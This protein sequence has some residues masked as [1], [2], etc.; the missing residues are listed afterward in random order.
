[1]RSPKR[2]VWLLLLAVPS[3]VP[4]AAS[5]EP[6]G[7][8]SPQGNPFSQTSFVPDISFILDAGAVVRNL[9]DAGLGELVVPGF[10]EA[11]PDGEEESGPA[12]GFNLNYAEMGIHSTVDPYFDVTAVFHLHAEGFEIEE[13]YFTTRLLPFGLR[14]TGG[15]FLSAVTRVNEQHAHAWDFVDAPLI[16]RVLFGGEGLNETGVRVDWV[17]P[18]SSYW[19]VGAEWLS[20]ANETSFG[21][22]GFRDASG[23]VTVRD[24]R[25][26]GLA[27]VLLR[28][29][30]DAGP[31]AL[32]AGLSGAAGRTLRDG[33]LE[34]GVTG[35]EAFEAD[36]RLACAGLTGRWSPTP[37]RSMTAQLEFMR[38][39]STGTRY[40]NA[41]SGEAPASPVRRRQSGLYGQVT[42]QPG[43]RERAGI[44]FDRI[45]EN[46]SW[47]ADGPER[48]AG[49][50]WKMSMMCEFDPTE[51]SRLRL[52]VNEDHSLGRIA[53]V[54]ARVRTVREWILQITLSA[55]SHGAHPF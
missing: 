32:L 30:A 28:T 14:V 10:G 46:R 17:P 36:T 8:A 20:G 2:L 21:R 53:G 15:K 27:A 44:R 23:T 34:S 43:K 24:V 5:A 49:G 6:G 55:G 37:E 18:L 40:V 29:A 25:G 22:T 7:A 26:P 11:E 47:D 31:V 38:R 12:E 52:Q 35:T 33:D 45:L 54:A 16:Q 1:M 4:P 51:F 13:G 48:S 39:T 50:L 9:E 19:R 41:A 3:A 42:M